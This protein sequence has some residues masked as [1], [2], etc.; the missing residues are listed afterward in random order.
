MAKKSN[1]LG[2]L[3]AAAAVVGAAAAGTYYYLKNRENSTDREKTGGGEDFDE[4]DI[5]DD[6][7]LNDDYSDSISSAADDEHDEAQAHAKGSDMHS[8]E[9]HTSDKQGNGR[10]YVSLDLKKAKE[11]ADALFNDVSEKWRIP[12]RRLNLLKNMK[13]FLPKWTKR[14]PR[15][16]IP[17]NLKMSPPRS[18]IPWN[19]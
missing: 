3:L 14:L 18:M 1:G 9:E 16:R 11:K 4:F 8:S 15:S 6:E 19:V 2:R 5:F 7:D 12:Y 13:P 17:K 10:S